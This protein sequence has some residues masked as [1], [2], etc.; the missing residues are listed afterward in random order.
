MFVRPESS[1]T[2]APRSSLTPSSSRPSPAVRARLP[3]DT[4]ITSASRVTA[5]PSRSYFS[6]PAPGVPDTSQTLAPR[7]NLIPS[8][9]SDFWSERE[10]S[11]SVGPA[12]LSSISTTVTSH[13]TDA[14]YDAISSPITPPPI[15]DTRRGRV[16]R[17]S[18]SRFVTASPEATA[19]RSPGTGGT[20]ASLPVHTSTFFAS[21]LSPA[22]SAVKPDAPFATSFAV[23]VT[24][25]TPA[26]RIFAPMPDTS[27]RTTLF[28]R[29]ITAA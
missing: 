24:T 28:L 25:V 9:S 16:S 17:S 23:A 6:L 21:Y 3:V 1:V 2:T 29:A 8:A 11:A 27:V 22:A 12:I 7:M 15:T 26:P 10:I 18:T 5:A 14:K 4:R 19:S 13:P 20:T